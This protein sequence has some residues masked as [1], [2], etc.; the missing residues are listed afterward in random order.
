MTDNHNSELGQRIR[1]FR[2]TLRLDQTEFGARLGKGK[3]TIIS[4]EKARTSPSNT[5]LEAIARVLPC[6]LTWLKTGNGDMF[7]EPQGNLM[8]EETDLNIWGITGAGDAFDLN[9]RENVPDKLEPLDKIKVSQLFKGKTRDCF[10]VKGDSMD[11][12]VRDGALIGVKLSDKRII[13]GKMYVLNL[14]H[15]GLTIKELHVEKKGIKVHAY[16]PRINDYYLEHDEINEYIIVGRV[17]WWLNEDG[18]EDKAKY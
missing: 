10:R 8:Q 1:E 13:T 16:N 4:W 14:P 7:A 15:E 6:N 2:I 5:M 9:M 17:V 3:N 12:K 18:D 11:D